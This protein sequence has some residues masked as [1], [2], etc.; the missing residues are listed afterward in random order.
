MATRI[1]VVEDN[2]DS[3]DLVALLLE[4]EGYEVV[5]ASDGY[6]GILAA[7]SEELELII[8]DL[9]MPH[10][11]GVEMIKILRA[12][13]QYRNLPILAITAFGM[14]RAEQAVK[15]GADR[16]LAKPLDPDILFAEIK[17]LLG[18]KNPPESSATH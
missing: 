16:T 18:R 5:V 1:L 12:G 3:R 14:E 15:A 11:D 2:L 4:H 6:Q 13:Q 8:V 7:A 9:N 17:E 10:I